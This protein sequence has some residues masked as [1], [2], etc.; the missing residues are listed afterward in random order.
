M[1]IVC[2]VVLGMGIFLAQT[3]VPQDIPAALCRAAAHGD[4]TLLR[5]LLERGASADEAD[6]AGLTALVHAARHGQLRAIEILVGSGADPNLRS[7][8]NDWTPLQH[9]IHKN[10]LDAVQQLVRFGADTDRGTRTGYTPLMMAAGYG[11]TATVEFLLETGSDATRLSKNGDSAL[12]LAVTGVLDID[13][14]TLGR[15]QTQTVQALVLHDPQ[16]RE[17][18][19]RLNPLVRLYVTLH[20]RDVARLLR[21]D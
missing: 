9:A 4:L 13:D 16:L 1:R 12:T 11:H 5:D 3:A 8:G 14:F 19:K 2:L 21:G 18:W 20:C 10:Q 15:C 17:H 6:A 7:G